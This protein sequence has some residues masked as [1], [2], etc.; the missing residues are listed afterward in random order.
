[1]PSLVVGINWSGDE[2][3]GSAGG[4]GGGGSGGATC[5]GRSPGDTRAAGKSQERSG[6][7]HA[8]NVLV[9]ALGRCHFLN[10][11]EKSIIYEVNSTNRPC[12]S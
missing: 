4:G 7:T 1:M 9:L 5:G 3:L 12:Q 11:I 8:I 10:L 6:E 2:D